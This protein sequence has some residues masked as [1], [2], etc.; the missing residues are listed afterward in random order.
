[1]VV[2]VGCFS[3]GTGVVLGWCGLDGGG[4]VVEVLWQ[5]WVAF[6]SFGV[7]VLMVF[8]V[9]EVGNEVWRDDVVV[10]V[11]SWCFVAVNFCPVGLRLMLCVRV[12]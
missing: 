7:F 4:E 10:V 3:E 5:R 1:V 9:L 12:P 8:W 11:E 6:G 2:T